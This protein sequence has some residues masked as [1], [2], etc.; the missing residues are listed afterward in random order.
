MPFALFQVL[1]FLLSAARPYLASGTDKNEKLLW[2]E[3]GKDPGCLLQLMAEGLAPEWESYFHR[4]SS[5]SGRG[6]W[7][8]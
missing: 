6:V 7:R 3:A 4:L 5:V 1:K 8:A 2:T